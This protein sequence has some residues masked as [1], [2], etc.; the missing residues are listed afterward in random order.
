MREIVNQEM[1]MGYIEKYYL[2]QIFNIHRK[3]HLRLFRFEKGEYICRN[4]DDMEYQFFLV[5]GEV[6]VYTTL[7]NGKIYLIRI[8]KPLHSYGDIELFSSST[9]VANAEALSVC[10][11]IGIPVSVIRKEYWN[12]PEFLRFICRSLG[13]RLESI[14]HMSAENV[15]LPLKNKLASYLLLHKEENSMKI[16]LRYSFIDISDHL[17][18][19]Y[20]HLNRTMKELEN[21]GLIS[22]N[23]KEIIVEDLEELKALAGDVYRY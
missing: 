12:Q 18:A 1:L 11:C 19:T 4:G 22:R 3:H 10:V 17:G 8:E 14:S 9:Y 16:V 15:Y 5:D 6:K 7:D 2:E 13:S 23:G 20:R 21:E